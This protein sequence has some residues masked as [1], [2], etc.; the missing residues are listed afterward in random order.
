MGQKSRR[1][2][3]T[4]TTTAEI[5][6]LLTVDASPSTYKQQAE[7][8]CRYLDMLRNADRI[9]DPDNGLLDFTINPHVDTH[10]ATL[11]DVAALSHKAGTSLADD[12]MLALTIGY[13][14]EV[15]ARMIARESYSSLVTPIAF[16]G[17]LF[18]IVGVAIP[19]GY[20]TTPTATA[21]IVVPQPPFDVPTPQV[22]LAPKG[23]RAKRR[24]DL[25]GQK[26]LP[27]D[28]A[29]NSTH[30]DITGKRVRY[31]T[32][33]SYVIGRVT[34]GT[35]DRITL[36][37]ELGEVHTDVDR[38][39]VTVLKEST[40]QLAETTEASSALVISLPIRHR[41]AGKIGKILAKADHHVDTVE[42][43]D[44]LYTFTALSGDS[45][46][47]VDVVNGTPGS[48][49]VYVSIYVSEPSSDVDGE[50]SLSYTH[51]P[52]RSLLGDHA[53]TVNN[54]PALLRIIAD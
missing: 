16:A 5:L 3:K 2:S 54:K 38:E 31:R 29:T 19:S 45:T 35:G 23:T 6:A 15:H 7:C 40:M 37:D 28:R 9:G 18:G 33:T 30:R 22:P 46:I 42:P 34:V 39:R 1:K 21:P 20:A 52:C 41:V 4:P 36:T 10:W 51:P 48:C 11:L 32:A 50:P 27:F 26:L 53:I 24:D 14:D 47:T 8:G 25:P 17:F 44:S 13:I 43:D 49:G 12:D